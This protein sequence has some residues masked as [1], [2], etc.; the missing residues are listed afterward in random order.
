MKKVFLTIFIIALIVNVS[1]QL[2]K[3]DITLSL[4]G[5][6]TTTNN[7]TGVYNNSLTERNS[8]LVTGASLS[9]IRNNFLFGFGFDFL[10]END[11]KK[12]ILFFNINSN[13]LEQELM[14]SSILL[15]NVYVGYYCT[16]ANNLCFNSNLKFSIGALSSKTVSLG[17]GLQTG[18]SLPNGQEITENATYANVGIHPEFTYF[19][20]KKFGLSLYPG[21]ID[22]SFLNWNTAGSTLIF[23]FNPNNWL[24]GVKF[25]L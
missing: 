7:Y 16:I 14:N 10:N 5:M 23:N 19:I 22:Y 9:F 11:A 4:N 3:G 20:S 21:G 8:S 6:Y 15:P 13:Q 24:V 1:A 25:V 17:N 2:K 12:S 18:N